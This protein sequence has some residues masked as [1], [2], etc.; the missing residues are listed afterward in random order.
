MTMAAA[1][2][3]VVIDADDERLGA[4]PGAVAVDADG[5]VYL[6]D[7]DTNRILRRDT[8]GDVRVVA[9]TGEPAPSGAPTGDGEPADEVPIGAPV[10]LAVG[11]D[12]HVWF[13]DATTRT[14]RVVDPDGELG[15]VTGTGDTPVASA[16]TFLD[17]GTPLADVVFGTLG[18]LALDPEGGV[19]VTDAGSGAIL[20]MIE[21]AVSVVAARNPGQPVADGVPMNR[22][23]VR[24][25]GAIAV[26]ANGAGWFRDASALR[27]IGR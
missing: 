16:G 11:G 24:S 26:D 27:V 15:T 23:S 20:R 12:G 14:V 4:T 2:N 13:L 17:D 21:G 6:A 25:P 7:V 3:T 9:G 5:A 1:A 18:A 22:S 8:D 10:G 19:Y